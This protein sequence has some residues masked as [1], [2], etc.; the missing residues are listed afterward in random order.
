MNE[1]LVSRVLSENLP[2]VQD[3][4]IKELTDAILAMHDNKVFEI[5]RTRQQRQSE[6]N[7]RIVN[8]LRWALDNVTPEKIKGRRIAV[9]KELRDRFG[10][11]FPGAIFV[12]RVINPLGDAKI[13]EG[14]E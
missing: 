14:A 1:Y 13:P 12:T 10:L 2:D 11:G 7:E 8:A 6:E 9:V 3:H 5:L 4:V